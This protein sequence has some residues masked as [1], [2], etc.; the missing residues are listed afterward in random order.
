MCLCPA[1]PVDD[2][3]KQDVAHF[4]QTQADVS[5]KQFTDVCFNEKDVN[6]DAN[7]LLS[8]ST[9]ALTKRYRREG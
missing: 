1:A 3:R 4:T 6:S 5:L 9:H 8:S 7:P 2:M